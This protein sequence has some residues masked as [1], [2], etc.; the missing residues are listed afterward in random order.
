L[1]ALKAQSKEPAMLHVAID[2]GS[3][4]S[5]ICV[6]SADGVIV[7]ERGHPTNLLDRYLGGLDSAR[8][9]LE[10]CAEA[11][12][13]ADAAR[14]HGHEVRVVPATM[15][16]SL[17]VGARRTKTDR[18][19]AQ[20]LSE[21][22][23]RIDLP[24]VHI[25]ARPSRE[26]KSQCTARE[27]LVQART[28]LINS[29]RGWMRTQLKAGLRATPD[30][31]PR[32]A[33][34]DLT[35]TRGGVPPYIERQLLVIEALNE[36]LKAAD[37]ELEAIAET[38]ETTRRLMTAP[39]IGP[40]TSLRFFAALDEVGRFPS[41]HA[42]EA[43]LGLTP[44]ENSSSLRKRRTSITKAGPPAVRRTLIQACWNI[45]RHRPNDPMVAWAKQIAERRGR[46]VA[47]V[48]MARKLAGILYAMWRD[49]TAYDSF[50]SATPLEAQPA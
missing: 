38:N 9:I 11:F 24:S 48:A 30:S 18:R 41:A 39:G 4:Q 21:V 33:R 17:G 35:D 6:R 47:V 25:P 2:L 29:V 15:V 20:I 12:L 8:V 1:N 32:R 14:A 22:S 27:S 50:R 13:V 36:Q 19:D 23:C 16:R 26:I 44:G 28:Q 43:Y 40:V 45:L 7:E 5:Q 49:G 42:V 3:R 31:F 34:T 46:F 10:T 37:A